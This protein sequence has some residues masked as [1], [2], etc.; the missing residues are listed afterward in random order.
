MHLDT[1]TQLVRI[2][3]V[4]GSASCALL[5]CAVE[6]ES[7]SFSDDRPAA[8]EGALG[9]KSEALVR[10]GGTSAGYSCQPIGCT[11]TGDFDCNN[12][13]EDG[14]CGSWPAKCYKRGPSE[15]CIC[16]PWVRMTTALET[17]STFN[18]GGAVLA[19]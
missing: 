17:S 11:C 12:M 7:T 2:L 10:G 13:F 15:Y 4:A 5:G 9:K 8:T 6:T 16:A 1:L 19:R 14:A 18:G 3:V